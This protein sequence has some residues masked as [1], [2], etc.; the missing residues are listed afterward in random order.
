MATANRFQTRVLIPDKSSLS[1]NEIR[2]NS[3]LTQAQTYF[4]RLNDLQTIE[5]KNNSSRESKLDLWSSKMFE[6]IDDLYKS[7]L[8]DLKQSFEQ[9]KLFQQ[10]M[11]NILNTDIEN[12]LDGKKLLAIE[13]EICILKCL[14]YQLDL[15]K[16]KIEGKLKLTNRSEN[17]QFEISIDD[18]NSQNNQNKMNVKKVIQDFI[19]RILV[20]KDTIEKIENLP[21]FQEFVQMTTNQINQT[22]PERVLTINGNTKISNFI[23]FQIL[24]FRPSSFRC[25]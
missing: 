13:H 3:L 14:T 11:I 5:S 9:L 6:K 22:T 17:D 12:Y 8:N 21:L 15:T 1:T 23:S 10:M 20:H 18:E 16:V 24:F 2:L 4:H 19:Y 7:C 25:Y